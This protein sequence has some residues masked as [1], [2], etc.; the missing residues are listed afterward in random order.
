MTRLP[1]AEPGQPVLSR[2]QILSAAA[3]DEDAPPAPGDSA[4]ESVDPAAV[5]RPVTALDVIEQQVHGVMAQCEAILTMIDS[6]RDAAGRRVPPRPDTT[7]AR[8]F[9]FGRSTTEATDA[10]G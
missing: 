1:R 4:R 5:R 2:D 9:A 6:M 10:E 3:P 7:P 8:P